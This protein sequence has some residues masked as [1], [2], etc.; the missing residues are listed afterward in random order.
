MIKPWARKSRSLRLMAADWRRSWTLSVGVP[1]TAS[2][3][4]SEDQDDN[5]D[6]DY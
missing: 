2:S 4:Q 5:Q 6:Y 3:D 1:C